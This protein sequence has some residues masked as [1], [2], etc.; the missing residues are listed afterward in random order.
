MA[1]GDRVETRLVG[2]VA[3]TNINATV[4]VEVPTGKTWVAKQVILCNTANID[5]LVYL[6]IG[7]ADT[8]PN[9][10]VSALPI[11]GGDTVVLDTALVLAAGECFYGYSDRASAVNVVVVGWEKTN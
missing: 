8:A 1:S 7:S 3:L 4:G 2:P 10:F 11:A 6:A 9:R 5:R